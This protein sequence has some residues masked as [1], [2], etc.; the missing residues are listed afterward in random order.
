[1]TSS[2]DVKSGSTST[3]STKKD[4]FNVIKRNEMAEF[5]EPFPRNSG[6]IKQVLWLQPSLG[7]RRPGSNTNR[8]DSP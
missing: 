8:Q 3:A 7:K 4:S 2:F 1:M 6:A 5:R